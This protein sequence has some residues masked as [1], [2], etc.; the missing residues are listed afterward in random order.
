MLGFVP[1]SFAQSTPLDAASENGDDKWGL[2][3]LRDP[4][5]QV[6]SVF[7]RIVAKE[8]PNSARPPKFF[9]ACRN[10][11][12]EAFVDW[13]EPVAGGAA[14]VRVAYRIGNNPLVE[15]RWP[16][17][18]NDESLFAPSW[19]GNLLKEMLDGDE[20]AIRATPE[21]GSQRAAVF[22]TIGLREAL[23]PVATA[24]GWTY[25]GAPSAS[26]LSEIPQTNLPTLASSFAPNTPWRY[27]PS[28]QTAFVTTPSGESSLYIQCIRGEFL[29]L[30]LFNPKGWTSNGLLGINIDAR[31][32]DVFVDYGADEVIISSQQARMG[33]DQLLIDALK[34]GDRVILTGSGTIEMA[35][36]ERT[37]SLSG[38]AKSISSVE[39]ACGL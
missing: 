24:C 16:A 9:I 29:S 8:A 31:Q 26:A 30:V 27:E 1:H 32:H 13:G 19:A 37:F 21:V 28:G 11:K 15:Q 7:I 23:A 22:D 17:S 4:V 18:T 25:P 35:E 36:Q 12:T 5:T 2:Q 33:I 3:R 34:S 38:A 20:W 39:Q 10:N 6:D 14:N